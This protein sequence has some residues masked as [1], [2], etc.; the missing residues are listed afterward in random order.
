[1]MDSGQEAKGTWACFWPV[2]F[3]LLKVPIWTDT[4]FK[5]KACAPFKAAIVLD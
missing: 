1:M 4:K 5:T 3:A 2:S